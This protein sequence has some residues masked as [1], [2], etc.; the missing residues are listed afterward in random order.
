MADLELHF[1][2]PY[3]FA[4]GD[5]SLFHSSCAT[6]AGVYLWTFRQQNDGGHLIHYVGETISFA[7]RQREHLIHVLSLNYGMFDPEKAQHGIAEIL[8]PGLWR[9]KSADGPAECLEAYGALNEVVKRYV[10]ALNVFFAPTTVE[11]LLRKHVEGCVGW[12]LRMRHPEHK[13][14]YPDDNHI[15]TSKDKTN[16]FLHITSAEPIRGL[17]AEIA[18]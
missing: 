7:K 5:R 6:A 17:D 1:D 3:T 11:P 10:Q 16:G 14:L 15:G 9:K 4:A 18:Y 8:W 2:G 13:V 12:N